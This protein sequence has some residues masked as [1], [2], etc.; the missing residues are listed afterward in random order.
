M[1]CFLDRGVR[2]Y[3]V[4]N[5]KTV[6]LRTPLPNPAQNCVFICIVVAKSVQVN[7]QLLVEASAELGATV[8]PSSEEAERLH[9][10]QPI[11]VRLPRERFGLT[12]SGE[13]GLT[14][15]RPEPTASPVRPSA[16]AFLL[17]PRR[18]ES[19]RRN[20]PQ[21]ISFHAALRQRQP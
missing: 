8:D 15:L 5:K 9:V 11:P 18:A 14:G 12:P 3:C 2:Y 16:I 4:G 21:T 20:A 19:W 10:S 6:H 17:F 1:P 13:T 7:M